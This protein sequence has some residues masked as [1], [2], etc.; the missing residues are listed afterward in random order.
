MNH[1]V[2]E[3]KLDIHY[4]GDH[5]PEVFKEVEDAMRAKL[6]KLFQRGIAQV[7]YICIP[8]PVSV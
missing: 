5:V 8:N 4:T 6:P 1:V 7:R 3:I 2:F